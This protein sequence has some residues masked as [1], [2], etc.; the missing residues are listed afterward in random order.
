MMTGQNKEVC[1]HC[2]GSV[3]LGQSI[4]ECIMCDCVIHTR[5]FDKTV[6]TLFEED[7]YCKNCEHKAVQRYNPFKLDLENDELDDNDPVFSFT[8]ILSACQNIKVNDFN[9]LYPELLKDHMSILFQN[10]DGVKSNFDALATSLECYTEKF[11]IIALAETNVG[12]QISDT[13]QLTNYTPKYQEKMSDKNKGSGVAFYIHNSLNAIDNSDLSQCT[14]NLETYFLTL[15]SDSDCPTTVGVLY[16]PPSG[17]LDEALEEL[18]TILE[19]APKQTYIAGDFNIDLHDN[20]ARYIEKLENTLFSKGFYPTIST[21]THEKPGCKPSCIDNIITNNIENVIASGTIAN[22][23]THHHQIFQIFESTTNKLNSNPKLTQYY[24]YC[25]SNVDRFIE[26][27]GEDIGKTDIDSFGKFTEIFQKN[28]DN[29]CKLKVPKTSKRTVQNN[30]W[31]TSGIIASIK[32][33]DELYYKWRK[34]RK[35]KCKE[36]ELD[37]RGGTCL[38]EICSNKRYHYAQYKEYRKALKNIRKNAKEKFYKGKFDEKSGDIKKTWEIINKIRG[39]NKRQIKPQFV[40]NNEKI[41]NRR[42]IANEFNKYFVSLASD[43][44]SAYNELG[45]L[46]IS[47]LPN[48]MDYL[49]RTNPSSIFMHDCSPDEIRDIIKEFQNGKSS[50][51]PIHVIKEASNIISPIICALYNKCMKN[52]VFPDELKTGRISPIYKKENEQLLEN[53]RPVSTLPIFGKIFEKVIFTR[54]YSFITSK[55]LIYENQYGFRKCHS[56]SHAINYS[57]THI[58]KLIRD[59]KHVLGIFIDLSKAFDT[60]SH[61]KLMKK[62]DRYGV[63]GK[64]HSLICSY[65]SNRK[66]YVSVLGENS[67]KLTVQYGVPQG[68][69]LG[70]LL[71]IIYINDIYNSTKLGQFVLFADDTNIFVSDKCI[72]TVYNKANEVLK[73]VNQYMRCN[74]LHINIKKCCY[75]HFKP[76]GRNPDIIDDSNIL[77]LGQT[78]IKRVNETKFLGVT[79]DDKLSWQPHIK[80]LNSKLKCEIGK[81][82]AIRNT[83]PAEL[84]DNLYHTLF[85]SHLSYGITAWVVS[86]ILP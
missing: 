7:F 38:C 31:I 5:C 52:G 85:E 60:I 33:C 43:L 17:N 64:A 48:F 22:T 19:I 26:C 41:K 72:K 78:T 61:D 46:N 45:E 35:K 55:N 34:S 21:V 25:N 14:K 37:D 83:I 12:P 27:L 29:T 15:S 79:I 23:I 47:D 9:K 20:N 44:N 39:K 69:V 28:L 16:R 11:P 2:H 50:D 67:D 57:A 10:I 42:V 51:I 30:P 6:H 1:V 24:D 86:L 82:N 80:Q 74:L 8:Q 56:T 70:P 3:N 18:K 77:V 58:E 32:H 40:I 66:Q 4:N 49:P 36:G 13:Y 59:K 76:R 63:R 81:L 84:Y 73:S 65:L 75:M 53:Y 54:L 62:L 71:F 68:S